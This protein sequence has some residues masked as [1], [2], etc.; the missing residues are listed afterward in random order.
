[1]ALQVGDLD[2]AGRRISVRRS[3]RKHQVTSPESGKPRTVYVPASTIEVLRGWL[4][5]IR[6]EA[7]VRGQEPLWL[8]PGSTGEPVDDRFPRLALRRCLK[9]AGITRRIRLHDLRHTY[10]SLALQRGVPLL[11]VSRQLGHASIAIPADVYGHLAPDAGQ[12]VAAAWEAILTAPGR[13]PRAT[14]AHE[15]A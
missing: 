1:M 15:T 11:Q 7:A 9:L 13:N 2:V 10:A 14:P 6:A 4:E 3:L 8:F 5:T 12:E